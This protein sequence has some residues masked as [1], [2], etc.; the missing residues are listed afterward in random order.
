MT[1]EEIIWTQ[2]RGQNYIRRQLSEK[3]DGRHWETTM[4]GHRHLIDKLSSID[5]QLAE[6]IIQQ[7]SLDNINTEEITAA[8]RRCTLQMIGFPVLCGSSY[9]N[10]GVQTLMDSVVSYLPSPLECNRIY[11]SFGSDLAARAFKVQHDDQRGV[12]TFLR[13][14]S[15][16]IEKGQR[17][18][19]LARDKSEQVCLIIYDNYR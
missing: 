19:N 18:Y 2:G 9:K 1:R 6:T 11:K 3:E 14:Y 13:L 12:L 8:I 17:I 16:D 15:G 5:D 10:I 4:N 7:E